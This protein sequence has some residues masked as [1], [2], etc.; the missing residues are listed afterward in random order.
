MTGTDYD[1][2]GATCTAKSA[3]AANADGNK[4]TV[5]ATIGANFN[6]TAHNVAYVAPKDGD[7]AETNPLV[8]PDGTTDTSKTQTDNDAQA[9]LKVDAVSIGDYVWWDNNRDGQ[10]TAG[11]PVVPDVT[12]NLIK[13]GQVVA[14]TKTDG[15]GYYAFGD[16]LPN[17]A[18]TVEF[19][20]PDGTS[21]TT[22]TLGATVSDSNPDVT[23]GKADV[24]TPKTGSN[25]T[26]ATKAD[27]PTIDAGFVQINLRLAKSLVTEGPFRPG[28]TVT[29]ELTPHNDGPV[30]ALAGWWV[31]DI[32]P[33]GLTLVSMTGDGYTC[34]D[35]TCV[36]DS[37]LASGADGAVITVTATIN[38]GF[39]GV[40]HNVA[41]I[42]PVD[43]EVDET[44]PLAV[45]N[46]ST[47]TDDTPTDNDAQASL[48]V[49]RRPHPPTDPPHT[50][51]PS[52]D[53]PQTGSNLSPLV[54]G[55]LG[56]MMA[57]GLG[58]IVLARR[59]RRRRI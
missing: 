10:Q 53:L 20:K 50:D 46:S 57:L 27:D 48:T 51:K 6:G 31:E 22:Q 39:K 36:S 1:C 59:G 13:G 18:Y 15:N 11:E 12:V 8:V 3:L 55:G 4:I 16:L 43:G 54:A 34:T 38:R 26:E 2:T 47:N 35:A 17:T 40:A 25:L 52:T 9:D 19:V 32:L 7:I 58:L 21:F 49:E 24:T 30:N 37:G 28:Q 23:T 41:Y 33:D 42:S 14:T 56:L 44:N 29:F 45:P 5:V